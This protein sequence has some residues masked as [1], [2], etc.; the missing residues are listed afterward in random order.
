MSAQCRSSSTSSTGAPCR[1][2]IEQRQRLLEHAQLRTGRARVDER[3]LAPAR[4]QR[5]DERLVRQLRA[6][7][8]E[9]APDEHLEAG[10]AGVRREL[11]DQPRLADPRLTRDQHRR[12]GSRPR[13]PQRALEPLELIG[14]PDQ[15]RRSAPAVALGIDDRQQAPLA[16]DAGE[17]GGSRGR[18]TRARTR[19]RGRVTVCDT[20]TSPGR[21]RRRMA[22]ATSRATPR[23]AG[24][25]D[26][27]LAGVHAGAASMPSA[28]RGVIAVA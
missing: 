2:A 3:K 28:G 16:A 1:D 13:P 12:P 18:R 9:A 11:A 8:I 17:R 24:L 14:A 25:D 4:A 15:R 21:P 7:E 19:R 6:D 27:D 22:T 10:V 5:V 23:S 20:S 26:L